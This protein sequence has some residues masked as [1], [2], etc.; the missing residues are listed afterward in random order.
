MKNLE[1]QLNRYGRGV[2]A[3]ELSYLGVEVLAMT[4]PCSSFIGKYRG[5]RIYAFHDYIM[6]TWQVR[7]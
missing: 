3:K 1:H 2:T 7:F 5:V 6:N 4:T